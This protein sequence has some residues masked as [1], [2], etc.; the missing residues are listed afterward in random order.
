MTENKDTRIFAGHRKRMRERLRSGGTRHLADYELLEILLF[1][2]VPRRNTH[3]TA[4]LLIH[5]FGS[6]GKVF[7]AE[8]SEL[9]KVEG[10]GAE[11]A[12]LITAVGRLIFANPAKTST[13]SCS[14]YEAAG[15]FFLKRY[16]NATESTVSVLSLDANLN[17]LRVED[18]T[19]ADLASGKITPKLLV[20]SALL[21]NAAACIIAHNHPHSGPFPTDGDW[22]TNKLLARTLSEFDVT[23]LESYV[24]SGDRYCGM[25]TG[26]G[27]ALSERTASRKEENHSDICDTLAELLG[28]VLPFSTKQATEL[29]KSI[30][31][32][33]ITRQRLFE[34]SAQKLKALGCTQKEAELLGLIAAVSA[35]AK[36][37]FFTPGK[38]FSE[39]EI[40]KF[41]V[42]A[43]ENVPNETVIL[44]V[45]DKNGKLLGKEFLSDG[46]VNFSSVVPRQIAEKCLSLGGRSVILAHNH[47]GGTAEFSETDADSTAIL[48]SA[49]AGCGISLTAHYAVG[50]MQCSKI[51]F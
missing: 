15:E 5:R 27:T 48:S 8:E 51:I 12:A 28:N 40:K 34:S 23:L 7:S 47:P 17:F 29:S 32:A 36:T 39:E 24:I 13:K 41:L 31:S 45:F 16:E 46:T 10:V 11:S 6:L 21:A 43:F 22:E 1:Y 4:K 30:S 20:D 37:E 33:V 18:F 3:P 2:S 19:G 50:G 49:L 35:R 14:S 26:M 38:A 42:G 25:M 44:I 9:L